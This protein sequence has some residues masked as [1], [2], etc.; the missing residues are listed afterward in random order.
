MLTGY[1][2]ITT[3]VE[4]V[5]RGAVDYLTKPVDADEILLAFEPRAAEEEG[6]DESETGPTD[7][8]PTLH[9]V[10]WEHIQRVLTACGGNVSRTAKA[11]GMHR[12]TLQRKLAT[13]PPDR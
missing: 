1:G 10:E 13:R 5:R 9:R 4:A 7:A 3:A 8:V 6:E 2:S 11:L 12:R